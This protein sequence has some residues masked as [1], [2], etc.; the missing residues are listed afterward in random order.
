MVPARPGRYRCCAQPP[1]GIT[2]AAVLAAGPWPVRSATTTGIAAAG[3]VARVL[4]F[5]TSAEA[6]WDSQG[7]GKLE[8]IL[9][10]RIEG[11]MAARSSTGD[12]QDL[13]IT[14]QHGIPRGVPVLLPV[15]VASFKE[16]GP[17]GA[18]HTFIVNG[19]AGTATGDMP[20][21][22]ETTVPLIR[23]LLL[24]LL[25]TCVVCLLLSFLQGSLR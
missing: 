4:P 6:A 22:S 18:V 11:A 5:A 24:V 17:D 13:T 23:C 7:R 25:A 12:V 16:D 8:S 14:F 1:R 21:Y 10:L 15:W 3:D 20:A 19:F 9:R 2:D